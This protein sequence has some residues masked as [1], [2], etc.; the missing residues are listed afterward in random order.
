MQNHILLY[1][2]PSSSAPSFGLVL[3]SNVKISVPPPHPQ[4]WILDITLLWHHLNICSHQSLRSTNARE[5]F[6][7]IA[8]YGRVQ[9]S[10][11]KFDAI[12]NFCTFVLQLLLQFN[13]IVPPGDA[14]FQVPLEPSIDFIYGYWIINPTSGNLWPMCLR[15]SL[16]K[17]L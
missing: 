12:V 7:D 1:K 2:S 5:S 4:T 10:T 16:C 8:P 13:D 6:V 11:Q 3:V 9:Y 15:S 14:L 17:C